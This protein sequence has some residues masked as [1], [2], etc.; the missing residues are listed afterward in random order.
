MLVGIS[1]GL[2]NLQSSG[3][4]P[5]SANF[6]IADPLI[7]A[8]VIAQIE[9]TYSFAGQRVD[10]T[11]RIYEASL[12]VPLTISV[13]TWVGLFAS[14][15]YVLIEAA[16]TGAIGLLLSAMLFMWYRQGNREAGWLILP[17]FAPAVS[18]ALFDLG[19]AAITLAGN[20]SLSWLTRFGWVR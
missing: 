15:T 19:T 2:S 11:L 17:S 3:L 5:L 7:Y 1:D 18:T 20:L 6:L 8:W 13:L 9:F 12:L 16:A 10:Q 14:N 4:V